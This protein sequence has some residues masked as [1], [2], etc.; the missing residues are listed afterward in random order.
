MTPPSEEQ[1]A[2]RAAPQQTLS[3]S[4]M[5]ALRLWLQSQRTRAIQGRSLRQNDVRRAMHLLCEEVRRCG[6]PVERLIIL[7]KEQWLTLT[8]ENDAGNARA[9]EALDAIIRTCIDEFYA[10]T[11]NLSGAPSVS[12]TEEASPS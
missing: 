4:S 6:L 8:E 5:G 2:S 11:A 7:V 12:S 9:R 10:S 1:S 3:S